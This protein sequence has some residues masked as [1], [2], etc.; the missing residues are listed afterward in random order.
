[1]RARSFGSGAPAALAGGV[2]LGLCLK[3]FAADILRVSGCSMEPAIREGSH[4]VVSRL[5]YGFAL[6]FSPAL[7]VRWASPKEN[8]VVIYLY[9]NK[10]VVKRCVAVAGDRL[11]FPRSAAGYSLAVNGR[12]F[13]LTEAQYRRFRRAEAVPSGMILAVGDNAE[14]SI[15]SRHYGFVSA[16]NIV[17]KVLGK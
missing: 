14:S 1:M 15:D 11:D 12:V 6:P 7:L 9:N 8:D 3:C 2:L 10:T 13:P 17:G 16:R 5:S 4:I